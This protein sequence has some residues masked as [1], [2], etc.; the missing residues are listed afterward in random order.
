MKSPYGILWRGV[1]EPLTHVC[2]DSKISK[3]SD[4]I[5]LLII[6]MIIVIIIII[7]EAE[8]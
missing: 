3:D 4:V 6:T 7:I 1:L 2:T 8:G 5:R